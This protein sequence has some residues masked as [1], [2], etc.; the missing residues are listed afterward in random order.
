[1][2]RSQ[3]FRQACSR[4][5]GRAAAGY[6]RALESSVPALPTA[7]L[8]LRTEVLK[9]GSAGQWQDVLTTLQ[10][11]R[12]AGVSMSDVPTLAAAIKA[13]GLGKQ[14]QHASDV[15]AS[16]AADGVASTPRLHS[17]FI[18][19]CAK[20]GDWSRA[21]KVLATMIPSGPAPDAWA[22]AQLLMPAP[23]MGKRSRHLLCLTACRVKVSSQRCSHISLS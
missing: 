15:L 21:L 16:A 20:C 2:L 11:A 9:L 19:A 10:A 7:Q 6:A 22:M 12:A 14:L 4:L 1:M 13:F 8:A 5:A 17:A 3:M 18:T 23:A